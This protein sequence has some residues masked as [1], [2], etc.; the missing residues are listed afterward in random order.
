M[1]DIAA[2]LA[3]IQARVRAAC[4]QAGRDPAEVRLIAV[5]KVHPP[6]AVEAALAA[7][8][9]DFGENYAQ[10]LQSKADALQAH[11]TLRWHFIGHLQ[12]NKVRLVVGRAA[13]IH[14]VD[15][16]RLA[17]ELNTRA[18]GLQEVLVEVNTGGEDNKSGVRPEEAL[19]LCEAL[20]R[21]PNLRLRGLMTIPP[22]VPTE[23]VA[24]YFRLLA[25]LAR[26]GRG[27]GLPLQELSMGMSGDFE[28]AI[29]EGATLVRVGTAIFGERPARRV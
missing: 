13:L 9:V 25:E 8:Q 24:P 16:L 5:S 12:R 22:A 3:Q 11:A 10:E 17:E 18:P 15:S 4:A 29:A 7:G 20:T 26:A 6:E 19:S 21:L 2:R 23:A 28:V 14:T 1:T 27:R